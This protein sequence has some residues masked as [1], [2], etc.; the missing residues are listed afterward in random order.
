MFIKGQD[1]NSISLFSFSPL[2]EIFYPP[3]EA[4]P[5]RKALICSCVRC[6]FRDA[7]AIFFSPLALQIP[8]MTA[9]PYKSQA[10]E[11]RI[12]P[13]PARK[14]FRTG[15]AGKDYGSGDRNEAKLCG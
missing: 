13:V 10:L 9:S 3:V 2:W 8:Q 6:N 4:R 5:I 11:M 1:S 14:H 7:K 15:K 12:A